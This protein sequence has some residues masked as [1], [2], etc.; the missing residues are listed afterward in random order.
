MAVIAQPPLEKAA[1][2]R[3]PHERSLIRVLRFVL[4]RLLTL[5]ATVVIGIYLT[6]VIANMC[7]HVDRIM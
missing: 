7:G 2:Q 6:I 5:F 3:T 1:P 4:V